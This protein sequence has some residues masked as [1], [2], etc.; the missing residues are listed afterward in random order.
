MWAESFHCRSR[1]TISLLSLI[2]GC[3]ADKVYLLALVGKVSA[4]CPF[5][6]RMM[7]YGTANEFKLI[8]LYD[9][10]GSSDV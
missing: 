4:G 9:I 6:F 1:A 7:P 8:R 5:F 2:A 3:V 10:P